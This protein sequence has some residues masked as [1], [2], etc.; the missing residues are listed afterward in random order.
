MNSR[1]FFFI[2]LSCGIIHGQDLQSRTGTVSY[3][4]GQSVYVQFENT[5]GIQAGDTLFTDT[6]G[7]KIPALSVQFLSSRSASCKP[8]VQTGFIVG[9]TVFAF[10]R[11]TEVE[12]PH[13]PAPKR[14]TIVIET[15]RKQKRERSELPSFRGRVSLQSSADFSANSSYDS[16]RYRASVNLSARNTGIQGL[17]LS[18]YMTLT[19]RHS[20]LNSITPS[21]AIRVYDFGVKYAPDSVM[22]YFFGRHLH[23]KTIGMGAIDGLI[24]ERSSGVFSYGAAAGSSP[25]RNDYGFNA[26]LFQAGVFFSHSH[27]GEGKSFETTAGFFQQTNK[28]KTD[29]RFLY[30][31]HS[32]DLISDASIFISNEIDLY[33]IRDGKAGTNVSLTSL[34]LSVRYSP[35]RVFSLNV[36]YDARR[37]VI[38]YE[39]FKP[40]LETLLENAMRQGVRLQATFRPIVPLT[41]GISAGYRFQKQDISPSRDYGAYAVYAGLP[42]VDGDLSLNGTYLQS[43]Y[44]NAVSGDISYSRL[45]PGELYASM[46]FRVFHSRVSA[47]SAAYNQNIVYTNLSYPIMKNL[48]ASV[49]YEGVFEKSGNISRVYIDLTQRF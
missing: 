43:N 6:N 2:L 30:L 14:D 49:S 35:A 36:S 24:V 18:N 23:P 31:Q 22:S 8:L 46:G 40:Y 34:F 38:F 29:R 33:G 42:Y 41:T 7:K 16:R 4:S 26:K 11:M 1:V 37:N 12:S 32:N 25:D 27:A 48:L 44:L 39:S 21:R 17:S 5:A 28:L 47:G 19:L 20:E 9:Q 13:T 3:I 45:F 15:F 10:A